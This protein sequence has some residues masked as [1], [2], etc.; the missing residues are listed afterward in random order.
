VESEEQTVRILLAEEQSLFRESIR[1]AL[2]TEP[3][4]RVVAVAE[5]GVRAVAEARRL[6]PDV[7]ILSSSL[8][9]DDGVMVARMIREEVSDCRVLLLA[10]TEDQATLLAALE[11]GAAGYL[12][13]DARLAELIDSTRA[14][15]EGEMFVPRAML[16]GLLNRLIARR[17][18]TD[19]TSALIA[20]L[21]PRER[22][23]LAILA[24][25]GNNDTIAQTLV[26]STETARTHVQNLLA[27][28]GVH[29][30][31]AASAFAR[32]NGIMEALPVFD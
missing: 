13:K 17:A 7:A 9:G 3:D 29:S 5:D 32:Q 11:A 25:G 28:L 16:R 31:L 4:L 12:S 14:V 30:R 18:E 10:D 23:V 21:T 20:R 8:L 24:A 26:I 19:R 1:S 2:E 22:E 27:K 6:R 15:Y